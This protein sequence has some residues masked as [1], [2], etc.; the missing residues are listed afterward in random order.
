MRFQGLIIARGRYVSGQVVRA[1]S[2]RRIRRRIALT[3]KAW[4]DAV[5][6]GKVCNVA[7]VSS[8]AVWSSHLSTNRMRFYFFQSLLWSCL[9]HVTSQLGEGCSMSM[10][11]WKTCVWNSFGAFSPMGFLEDL[12]KFEVCSKLPR[13]KHMFICWR[14][15]R[16]GT[17]M[18]AQALYPNKELEE[19]Q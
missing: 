18:K 1:S 19:G 6:G 12:K 17:R 16:P 9:L 13:S 5:R 4:E 14:A 11:L 8:V 10:M 3:E 7:F 15:R 2:P